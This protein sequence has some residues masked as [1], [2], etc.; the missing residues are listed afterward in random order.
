MLTPLSTVG[1]ALRWGYL[2]AL[3]VLLPPTC[4]ACHGR[5]PATEPV[6]ICANCYGKLPWWNTVQVLPPKLAPAVSSFAA[7]CLYEG[8]LREM[9][10]RLKFHDT[11]QMARP[12]ARLLLPVLPKDQGLLVIAVPSHPKR[13]RERLYNH[14]AL[15]ADELAKLKGYATLPTALVRLKPSSPQNSKTRAQRLKLS[16][17]DFKASE[18]VKGKHVLLVDDIFTTGATARA[19]A[20][21]LRKAG[22]SRV[23]VVTLAYTKPE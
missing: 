10:L 18:K 16:G 19:C 9:I 13:L 14:A 23:S 5:L 4:F 22:A 7:P 12:L 15:L 3:G 1:K 20:L 8:N 6:G 11:P 17:N 21:A 2:H